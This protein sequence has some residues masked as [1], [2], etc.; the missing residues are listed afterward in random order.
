[1]TKINKLDQL[2]KSDQKLFH[3]QDLA[4]LWDIPNRDT[5]YTTIKR[6]VKKGVLISVRKGIYS[7]LPLEQIDPARLGVA[8]IHS[9]SYLTC[10][11]ILA[12]EGVISQK[13]F[14]LTYVSLLSK[15]IKLENNFYIFRKL[16][17]QFLF[18]N[19]GIKEERE[20]FV[21]ERERAA[22]DMLYFNPKYYFD[23]PDLVNWE[24][25]KFIQRKV[26]YL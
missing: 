4:L 5:L 23:N 12:R 9:Y 25:V 22:A 20:V 3:T 10:E 14:P 19:E 26:G 18:Q 17:P 8:L 15:K 1:M 6:L 11:W 7:T 16:K 2:L 21:A 13:I 24:R